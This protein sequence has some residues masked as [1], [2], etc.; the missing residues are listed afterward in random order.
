[1][2][3]DQSGLAGGG[4]A[5][6][7]PLRRGPARPEVGPVCPFAVECPAS[8]QRWE[9]LTFLHWPFEPEVVRRRLPPELTV[10]TFDG[11][12]WVSLVPFAMRVATGRGWSLPWMSAFPETNVRTYVVD[13][14]GRRGVW[15]F[16]LDAA[17]LPAVLMARGGFRLPYL[18]SAMR[19]VRTGEGWPGPRRTL[20]QD[21]IGQDG[22][23]RDEILYRTRRR[24]PGPRGAS[25][26]VRVRIGAAY[27]AGELSPLDH[28]LTAR[29]RL[30]S[31]TGPSHRTVPA[32]HEPWPLHRADPVELDDGLLGAA[33]LAP[34][35]VE[36]LMH[37]SPGVQ[38]RI[39]RPERYL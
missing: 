32:C 8:I 11:Q 10:D 14:R 1:M 22:I 13:R 4:D 29:W 20:G 9:R 19:V 27:Q 34:P 5:V 33:G 12:A 36:P 26:R 28:F 35:A 39:G 30:Y 23:G 17:R 31:S 6:A 24:W 16:S 21:G 15:F 18:W 25:S 3:L 7:R 37:Y 38:V 2:Y